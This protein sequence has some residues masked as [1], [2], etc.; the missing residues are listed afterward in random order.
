[1]YP[2]ENKN[3]PVNSDIERSQPDIGDIQSVLR[4]AGKHV[5]KPGNG[6]SALLMTG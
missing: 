1:M 4:I 3:D 6:N 5:Y 2:E